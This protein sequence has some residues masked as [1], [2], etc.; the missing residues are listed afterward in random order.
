MPYTYRHFIPENTAPKG[1]KKIGVYD[2]NGKKVCTIPLG[3]L[4]PPNGEKLYSFGLLSDIHIY[5]IAAVAWHPETKFNNA[6]TFFENEGC[7]FAAIS[8]DLTQTGLT[9]DDTTTGLDTR[10]FAKYKEICDAH[11]VPV[12]AVCGNHESITNKDAY[13]MRNQRSLLIEYTGNDLYYTVTQGDDLFIFVGQ[14]DWDEVMGDD[15]LQWLRETLESNTDKRCFVFIH[16]YIEEDS[17]DPLDVREN[18]IFDNWGAVKTKS[19]MDLMG[20]H[21]NAIL[22][23]G[24]SHTVFESQELDKAA[25]YT[26][27]NGFRSVHVPSLARPLIVNKDGTYYNDDTA[28]QGYIVDVYEDCIVLRGWDF[29]NGV[30]VPHGTIKI[31]T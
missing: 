17:G 29:V 13:S 1:A 8:G 19:F 15:A 6:L 5:P 22:F 28:A 9:L 27:R 20:Q 25:N 23:H 4:T 10:Q 14:P 2:A 11:T 7:A 3:G 26:E 16:P 31:T 24:H 12:Y 21:K 18:S 30:P